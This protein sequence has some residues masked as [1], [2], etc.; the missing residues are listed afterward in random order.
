VYVLQLQTKR[1]SKYVSLSSFNTTRISLFQINEAENG[2]LYLEYKMSS[3]GR[4][5][6]GCQTSF[7]PSWC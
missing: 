3:G 5:F 7:G 4:G 6:E 2:E 1:Q